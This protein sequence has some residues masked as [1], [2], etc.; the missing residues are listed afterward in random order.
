MKSKYYIAIIAALL[1]LLLILGTV[2]VCEAVDK[3]RNRELFLNEL[4]YH[5]QAIDKDLSVTEENAVDK[6]SVCNELMILDY[7][8]D[9]QRKFTNGSFYYENPGK[10][11][12]IADA[13]T[14]GSCDLVLLKECVETSIVN[15]SSEQGNCENAKLSYRQTS[16][17][18]MDLFSKI[19]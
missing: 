16:E 11:G 12:A 15:L 5:L 8:C 10:F 13:V 3:S 18:L 6:A 17:I 9:K 1:A 4:Y 2:L 7:M 14:T 19:N